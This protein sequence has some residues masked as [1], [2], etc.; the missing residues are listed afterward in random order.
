MVAFRQN[1]R[2]NAWEYGV[3]RSI[4]VTKEEGKRMYLY[5]AFAIVLASVILGLVIGITMSVA[6]T[7]LF[8]EMGS[9]EWVFYMP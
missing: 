9:Q 6:I 7:M 1:T 3:L 4:G 2:E 8:Y 5:E